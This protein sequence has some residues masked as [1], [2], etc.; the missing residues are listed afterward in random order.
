M[1]SA[2]GFLLDEISQAIA[3]QQLFRPIDL[4]ESGLTSP[5]MREAH[6]TS[7]W[8]PGQLECQLSVTE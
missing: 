1:D 8:L 5:M 7:S 3:V 2:A 4:T 6:A